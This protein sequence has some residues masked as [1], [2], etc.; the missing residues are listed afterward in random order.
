MAQRFLHCATKLSSFLHSK[1]AAQSSPTSQIFPKLWATA[2]P[3]IL[4]C[5]PSTISNINDCPLLLTNFDT[6]VFLIFPSLNGQILNDVTSPFFHVRDKLTVF[7]RLH[8]DTIFLHMFSSIER[9]ELEPFNEQS[10]SPSS[11]LQSMRLP[12]GV[13][14]ARSNE[15]ES[16][17]VCVL[18]ASWVCLS[19]SSA[20]DK[21]VVSFDRD[22]AAKD[23]PRLDM[24][25]MTTRARSLKKLD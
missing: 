4:Q 22:A 15:I 5:P 17:D 8:S 23:V 19:A 16:V 11:I 3:L 12:S 25:R 18:R 1:P 13:I 9:N 21:M 10:T 24:A 2:S 7:P 6:S 20:L 14:V